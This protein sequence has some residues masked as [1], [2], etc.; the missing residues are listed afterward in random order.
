MIAQVPEILDIAQYAIANFNSTYD[1]TD[2]NTLVRIPLIA[3][4][5]E[6][7]APAVYGEV[8]ASCV[9]QSVTMARG[10]LLP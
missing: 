6:I 5:S 3:P 9:M 4:T 1:D 8:C 7:E 2:A 10:F